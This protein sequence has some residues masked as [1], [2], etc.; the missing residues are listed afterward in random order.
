MAT[1][2]FA[3]CTVTT[4]D[5]GEDDGGDGSG[6]AGSGGKASGGSS[7]GGKASGGSSSGGKASGGSGDVDSG[8]AE[9]GAGDNECSTCVQDKCCEEWL[10]CGND[11]DCSYK[12]ESNPGELICVQDCLINQLAD[13]GVVDLGECDSACAVG[14]AGLATATSELIAC[15]RAEGDAGLQNCSTPCFGIEL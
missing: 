2:A 1:A 9:C 8:P 10:D 13:A 15:I 5:P 3:G 14:S 6:G 7:S 11:P 4:D 12:S